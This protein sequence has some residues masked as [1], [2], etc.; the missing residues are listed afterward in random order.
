MY[1]CG[2]GAARGCARMVAFWN[3]DCDLGPAVGINVVSHCVM[4]MPLLRSFYMYTVAASFVVSVN[5]RLRVPSG[6]G[7]AQPWGGLV[8]RSCMYRVCSAGQV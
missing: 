4:C 2:C 1:R 5:V 6:D 3:G 7:R 8:K